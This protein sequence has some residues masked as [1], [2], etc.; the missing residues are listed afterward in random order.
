MVNDTQDCERVAGTRWMD[1]HAKHV[2]PDGVTLLGDDLSR[3][4]PLCALALHHGGHVLLVCKPDSHATLSERV[5]FWQA[6]DAVKAC[7]T[8]RRGG[9]F[10]A[11]TMSR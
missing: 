4:Q 2:A 3:N 9:R 8:R 11:V 1:T 5:A 7:A 6:H 10:T